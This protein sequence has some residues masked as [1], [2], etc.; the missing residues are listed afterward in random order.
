MSNIIS[1]LECVRCSSKNLS[2]Q[3]YEAKLHL[4]SNE[5][6]SIKTFIEIHFK[7]DFKEIEKHL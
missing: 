3:P 7:V 4:G 2:K 6:L 1:N 5:F